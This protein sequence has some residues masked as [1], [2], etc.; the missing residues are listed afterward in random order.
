MG[1]LDWQWSNC[2]LTDGDALR[3]ARERA[4]LTRAQ[5]SRQTGLTMHRCKNLELV[6]GSRWRTAELQTIA[7][8]LGVPAVSL[9]ACGTPEHRDALHA[10][11]D[12][13]TALS[14]DRRAQL[15]VLLRE[16]DGR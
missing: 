12:A 7:Q 14:P 9:T 3:A 1:T 10:L 15:D 5:L 4:G 2:P 8:R 16:D 11:R 6:S 13:V